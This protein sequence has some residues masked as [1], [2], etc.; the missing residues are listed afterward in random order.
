MTYQ[1]DYTFAAVLVEQGLNGIP[2]PLRS[3]IMFNTPNRKT[4]E[5]FL[6]GAIQ[7]YVLKAHDFQPASKKAPFLGFII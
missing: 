2:E 1:I 5:E 4:V 6:H 7:K 3:F